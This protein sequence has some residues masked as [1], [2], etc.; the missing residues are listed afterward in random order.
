MNNNI[1]NINN[2]APVQ[3]IYVVT[4]TMA[5]YWL[6]NFFYRHQRPLRQYWVNCLANEMIQGR[7]RKMVGV[8][9]GF[10][11]ET[12]TYHL[13]NGQ[14]TLNA[15]VKCGLPQTLAVGN[16]PVN[17]E[18]ELADLFSRFDTHLTRQ[19]S[20]SL[21]AHEIDVQ[22]GITRTVLNKITAAC[23]Y[24][25]SIQSP[26]KRN[27]PKKSITHDV[28]L[29]ILLDNKEL[30]LSVWNLFEGKLSG[31]T[32]FLQRKT[33]LAGAMITY[34]IDKD[35]ACE[36]WIGL[37]QDDGLRAK[38]PRKTLL[39]FLKFSVVGGHQSVSDRKVKSYPDHVLV[40]AIARAWNAYYNRKDLQLIQV[41][42]DEREVEFQGRDEKLFP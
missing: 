16:H 3:G 22:L 21:A 11:L 18:Y 2:V 9:F 23:I 15:I 17:S 33:S 12:K 35:V 28:K 8:D 1:S 14:H 26:A 27:R 4:P 42:W 19:L 30:A 24:Y 29:K 40:K 41:K 38:D 36:F 7:F 32:R 37:I 34:A 13:I 39:E 5:S 10:L 6:D 25:D 31:A 20:D